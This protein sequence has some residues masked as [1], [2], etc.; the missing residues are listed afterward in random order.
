MTNPL[1]QYE[2]I[3]LEELIK[4]ELVE[5]LKKQ[6]EEYLTHILIHPD[7]YKVIQDYNN[8]NIIQRFLQDI[9]WGFDDCIDNFR[10]WKGHM[11]GEDWDFWE[12]L[13]GDMS[14]YE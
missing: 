11:K 9:K 5:E 14:G 13:N 7:A 3:N 8:Q 6:D 4:R 12:I 10:N 2:N 1:E